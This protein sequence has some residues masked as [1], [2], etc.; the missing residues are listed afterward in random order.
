MSSEIKII[1]NRFIFNNYVNCYLVKNDDSYIL[2]DTGMPNKRKVIEKEIE[3]AG[4]HRGNLRLIILSHG[5]LDHAGNAAYFRKKFNTKIV[6][7]YNDAGM[8]EQGDIFWNRKSPNIIMKI[9]S[10]IFFG[11]KEVDRFV[12]DLYV[13]DGYDFSEYGFNAKVLHLSGHSSGSIG[14]LAADGNLFCGDLLGNITK[15]T[16]FSII[17]NR[18]AANASIEKLKI[19]NIKTVYPG[20]GKSFPISS[21]QKKD[22]FR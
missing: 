15:P 7:H 16:L 20:H 11:L 3:N 2:I 4:C 22:A 13:E 14:V 19:L 18:T 9:L 21:L 5:D 8:V 12:P 1:S 6:I 17:D 10:N